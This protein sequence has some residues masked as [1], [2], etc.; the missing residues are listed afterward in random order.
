[1][2]L[3]VKTFFGLEEILSE[4]LRKIG[5]KDIRI[6]KRAC[7]CE[8]DT[9]VLYKSN[10]HLRTAL[11]ILVP[12]Y[13]F[14]AFD[15]NRLYKKIMNFDWSEYLNEDSTFAIDSV[16]NSKRHKHSHYV[17]LKI[18]DAIVDQFREKTGK[19]PSIDKENP[20]LRIN[21]HANDTNF[22]ISLDSSGESL[23]RRGYRLPGHKAPLNEVLSAGMILLS[24]WD[25]KSTFIDPMCGTGTNLMEAAMIATNMPPLYRRKKFGFMKWKDYDKKLWKEIYNQAKNN[26]IS[27]DNGEEFIFGSDS[28]G[29]ALDLAK[30]SIRSF[31]FEEIIDLERLEFEKSHAITDTGMLVINPPYGE[32]LDRDNLIEFYKMMGDTMKQYYQ[33]YEAWVLSGNKDLIKYIGLKPSKKLTLYNGAIECK[34]HKYEMYKGSKKGKYMTDDKKLEN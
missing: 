25:G 13:E 4:E 20:D 10:L 26:I 24:G 19:R 11:R 2:K 7:L 8:G 9:N 33:G 31:G 30:G 27:L 1:L 16:I 28:S 21:V 17:A 22:T 6:S 5:A 23:H 18:K 15:E 34:F 3:I 29:K 32:R 12:I 14:V